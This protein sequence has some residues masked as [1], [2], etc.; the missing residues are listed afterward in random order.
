MKKIIIRGFILAA[1]ISVSWYALANSDKFTPGANASALDQAEL[2]L[3]VTDENMPEM[4]GDEQKILRELQDLFSD[5]YEGRPLFLEGVTQ[6]TDPADSTATIQRAEFGYYNNGS[7]VRIRNGGQLAINTASYYAVADEELKRIVVAP[8][9]KI[10]PSQLIPIPRAGRDL[11]SEGYTISRTEEEG[12][13]II[14]LLC[15]NHISCKEI[16][17]EYDA[18]TR[19]PLAFFSRYTDLDHPEDAAFDKKM[20]VRITSWGSEA[21]SSGPAVSEPVRMSG[22]NVKP[23]PGFETYDIVNLLN[24]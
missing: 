3:S 20:S 17:V 8:A 11:K 15:E 1:I 10:E 7:S 22:E 13:V 9:K 4:S 5:L 12:R 2:T 16:R 19:K 24:K 14:R 18:A 6:Y 21:P 23:G